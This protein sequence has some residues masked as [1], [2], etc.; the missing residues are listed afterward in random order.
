MLGYDVSQPL[1]YAGVTDPFHGRIL[2]LMSL[3]V[4]DRGEFAIVG[5]FVSKCRCGDS[6]DIPA[7]SHCS[8]EPEVGSGK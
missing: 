8:D 7:V 1:S 5:D 3:S 2:Q 4:I 6:P